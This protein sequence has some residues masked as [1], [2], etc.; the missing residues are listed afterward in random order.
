[1]SSD[2]D[3]DNVLSDPRNLSGGHGQGEIADRGPDLE[4][5]GPHARSGDRSDRDCMN[6]DNVDSGGGRG[7]GS[8]RHNGGGGDSDEDNYVEGGNC[9]VDSE[10]GGDSDGGG[11]G[12]NDWHPFTNR[13]HAQLVL[14]YMGSHRRNC[15]LVTFKAFMKVLKVTAILN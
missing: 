7:D 11:N 6:Y 14:L 2:S 13:V 5:S 12:E 15:D 8:D 9:D 10:G 4:C 3:S 1:M